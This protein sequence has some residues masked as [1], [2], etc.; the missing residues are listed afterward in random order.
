MDARNCGASSRRSA[1]CSSGRNAAIGAPTSFPSRGAIKSSAARFANHYLSHV[2][3][4][5]GFGPPAWGDIASATAETA[6]AR[7]EL[8]DTLLNYEMQIH[9]AL[10]RSDTLLAEQNQ[11]ALDDG[12]PNSLRENLFAIRG[13]LARAAVVLDA[14]AKVRRS[15]GQAIATA[16]ALEA[17]AAWVSGTALERETPAGDS[18][19]LLEALNRADTEI[20]LTRSLERKVTATLPP[21]ASKPEEQFPALKK[22]VIVRMRGAGSAADRGETLRCRQEIGRIASSPRGGRQVERTITSIDI[23]LKTGNQT[24][25]GRQVKYY[26]V[27]VGDSLESIYDEN[28]AQ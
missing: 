25:T 4:P 22:E 18:R 3:L 19:D 16:A 12:L 14:E 2:E 27:G 7:E 9:E 15:L 6:H 28:A 10:A 21:D 11:A 24:R 17:L 20:D 8:G 5:E 26:R 1:W 23:E 13:H